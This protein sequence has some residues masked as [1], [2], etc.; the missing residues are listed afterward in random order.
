MFLIDVFIGVVVLSAR[1]NLV[2]STELLMQLGRCKKL[3]KL[4][5]RVLRPCLPKFLLRPC[6]RAKLS[7]EFFVFFLA[8]MFQFQDSLSFI[9][10]TERDSKKL[11]SL[12]TIFQYIKII[13]I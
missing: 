13:M 2:L 5:Y 4:T 8:F 6:L 1:G 11:K 9:T 3:L 12:V 7:L 10:L